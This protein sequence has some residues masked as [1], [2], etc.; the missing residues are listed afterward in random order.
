M[1]TS[2]TASADYLYSQVLEYTFIQLSTTHNYKQ[3]TISF[4]QHLQQTRAKLYPN[5]MNNQAQC[6][7]LTPSLNGTKTHEV[8][9][10]CHRRG[11]VSEQGGRVG[12]EV[13]TVYGP[14][15]MEL[16]F[17]GGASKIQEERKK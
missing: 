8:K 12:G 9:C 7:C 3:L 11:A 10:P 13:R 2:L 1:N 16:Q 6:N 14:N 5:T 17:E 15:G 4:Q